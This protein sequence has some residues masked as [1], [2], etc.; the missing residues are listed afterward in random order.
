MRVRV[1]LLCLL[2][3]PLVACDS[4]GEDASP[5]ALV[6]GTW[7]RA[8]LVAEG[9]GVRF[10]PGQSY[11]FF[12][13]GGVTERGLYGT[14]TDPDNADTFIIRYLDPNSTV[15]G[16]RPDETAV[17][18]GDALVLTPQGGAARRYRRP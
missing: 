6:Q 13:S 1:S 4:G 7:L 11:E 12:S 9:Q 14:L 16:P 8:E 2:L 15:P 10:G 3:S 18:R 5:F 17:L